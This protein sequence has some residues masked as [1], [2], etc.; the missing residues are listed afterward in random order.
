MT[1]RGLLLP[2]LA[3]LVALAVLVGLGCWQLERL[4]W[5]N[6]LV[7]QVEAR[8]HEPPIPL[9]GPSRW[10]DFDRAQDEYRPVTAHG[11]FDHSREVLIY[12]VLS[13]TSRPFKGPGFWVLTPLMQADGSA[14]IVNRGFVPDDRRAPARRSEGQVEG[15]VTVTGLVRFP[16]EANWFVPDN[17]PE[18][19]VWYR[20]DPEEIGRAKGLE[21]VAPFTI[22]ADATPNPG[23]LPQGGETR[24]AF[25]N[26]HLEYALTW[27]GLA[28]TLVGVYVAFVI[29]RLRGRRDTE[30]DGSAS[31]GR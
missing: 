10:D 7:A 26:K 17:A 8:V 1:A 19:N 9:P 31:H 21:R 18:R 3:A 4:A 6:D 30:A 28:A 2:S 13:D 23:G 29:T 14:I 16:E 20:R 27:F 25:P 15:T 12:T 22:D 11:R 5:K 24:L